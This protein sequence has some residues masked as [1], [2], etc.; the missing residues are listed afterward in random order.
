MKGATEYQRLLELRKTSLQTIINSIRQE[1]H[2][3]WEESGIDSPDAQSSDFPLYFQEVDTMDDSMV[4]V[5]EEYLGRLKNRV[6]DLRPILSKI[7]KREQVV[8]ERIE[9]E[10]VD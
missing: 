7:Y 4:E 8:Q 5:H 3:L 1:I 9:L 2:S 10:Q 6:S